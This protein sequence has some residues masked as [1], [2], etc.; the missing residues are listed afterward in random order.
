MLGQVLSSAVRD[1]QRVSL[2]REDAALGTELGSRRGD[3][4]R[5]VSVIADRVAE[6]LLAPI[7]VYA[8]G[9]ALVRCSPPASSQGSD[10]GQTPETEPL[11]IPFSLYGQTGHIMIGQPINGE[12][13]VP[14]LTEALVELV[15]NQT[16]FLD[17]APNRSALKNQFIDDLL[18][19][20]LRD[21]E[22]ILR[23]AKLLRL[24]LTPPRG[25]ILI[26][27][28]DFI[29]APVCAGQTE[30]DETTVL[31]RAQFVI[32]SIVGF[33]HL[34]SDTICAYIGQG[35]VAVLKASNTK[36]LI[37]WANSELSPNQW[38]SSWANLAALKRAG[39]ALLKRV[40][41][42]TN[43]AISIGIG[44]Y[45]PGLRGLALSY[46][47]ARAARSLG[48]RFHGASGVY[49]LDELGIPAFVGVADE[50]TKVDLAL[51]LLSPLDH[52][53]DLLDTLEVFFAE[54]CCPSSTARRLAV[55]RNT[56]AYRLEKIAS[57]TG[58]D[59]RIFDDAVQI[60]L[61]LL[62]R[63]LRAEPL[64]QPLP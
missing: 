63:A 1:T 28:A 13:L 48:R 46:Q 64:G 3:F 20:R 12:T 24:D 39:R 40:S 58:L 4:R 30:P 60:R 45:H 17:E 5:S 27:A 9:V 21:E 14:R 49:C 54:N 37:A 51:Y 25:V 35:E 52:E 2:H 26:D 43:A 59:P 53:A 29:L 55:H 62:L 22:E 50:Q 7:T 19:G 36:N 6:L 33:F 34:P 57:L 18:H 10:T 8:Q 47:D 41:S 38:N 31:R 15:I 44:R 23:Q 61:A 42:D 32:S 11:H 56:L 16:K